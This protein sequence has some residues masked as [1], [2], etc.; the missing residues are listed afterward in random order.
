M[1]LFT[2]AVKLT[3]TKKAEALKPGGA[4]DH[5]NKIRDHLA[6]GFAYE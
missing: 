5:R 2:S 3:G 6:F 4:A 1:P